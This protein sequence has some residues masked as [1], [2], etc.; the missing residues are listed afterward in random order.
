M[1][2]S[3][4]Q[5]CIGRVVG[6]SGKNLDALRQEIQDTNIL[7]K[8]THTEYRAVHEYCCWNGGRCVGPPM[9]DILC[10]ATV[11]TSSTASL[12]LLERILYRELSL[13]IQK[14]LSQVSA[15]WFV[16]SD[17]DN[18][19]DECG[20]CHEFDSSSSSA[21][22]DVDTLHIDD[23]ICVEDTIDDDVD[24]TILKSFSSQAK[25]KTILMTESDRIHDEEVM[26]LLPPFIREVVLS[27]SA[28]VERI[29]GH[30]ANVL[31]NLPSED[32]L[33]AC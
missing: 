31:R 8:F 18:D 21:D 9:G 13:S 24:V 6:K 27:A 4:S 20:S 25:Q 22:T 12:Q 7:V 30:A 19:R 16:V 11:W 3:I 32:E 2:H 29:S 23:D 14:E 26:D 17:D 1:M 15:C 33:F 28:A 10:Y 5:S